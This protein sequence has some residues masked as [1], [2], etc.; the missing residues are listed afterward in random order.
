MLCFV[1]ICLGLIVD[2]RCGVYACHQLL[3]IF[4]TTDLVGRTFLLPKNEETGE[5]F[6]ARIIS[7]I[8]KHESDLAK[9][10]ARIKFLCSVNNN[11]YESVMSYNDII[12]CIS[13]N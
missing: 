7:A 4:N 11:E 10:P 5:R 2:C 6:R 9:D 12:S 13:D 1:V 8:D 3:L